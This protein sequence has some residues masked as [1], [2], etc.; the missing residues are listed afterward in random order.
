MTYTLQ[1][2][3][4]NDLRAATA[5]AI[6]RLEVIAGEQRDQEYWIFS[7]VREIGRELER[8]LMDNLKESRANELT[9]LPL[10]KDDA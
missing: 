8:A 7:Q 6:G 3:Q 9:M 2:K 4:Y 5:R 1:D 10:P